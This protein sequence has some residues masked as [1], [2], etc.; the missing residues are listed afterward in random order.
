MRRARLAQSRRAD[1][2]DLLCTHVKSAIQSQLGRPVVASRLPAPGAGPGFAGGPPAPGPGG[3][4]PLAALV[5]RLLFSGRSFRSTSKTRQSEVGSITGRFLL[6]VFT[7]SCHFSV[8]SRP[9]LF[10]SA[11]ARLG[12]RTPGAI[13]LAVSGVFAGRRG[14]T[15]AVLVGRSFG[16][17]FGAPAQ[18][19]AVNHQ[20]KAV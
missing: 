10:A 4:R 16:L 18:A 7:E 5:G 8:E 15:L 3:A 20:N 9:R 1:F 14:P 12:A 11:P 19:A 17:A 13:S 2:A 6:I